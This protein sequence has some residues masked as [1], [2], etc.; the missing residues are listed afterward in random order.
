M[1]AVR[2]SERMETHD[3]DLFGNWLNMNQKR[4]CRCPFLFMRVCH[5]VVVVVF[6]NGRRQAHWNA[7]TNCDWIR[8]FQWD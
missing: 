8:R 3:V 1:S 7:G 4:L 6:F 5:V 2:T